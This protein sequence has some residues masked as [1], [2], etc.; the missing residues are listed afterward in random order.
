MDSS[1]AEI[2]TTAATT[3][4]VLSVV[5]FVLGIIGL[6]FNLLIFVRPKLCRQP[7]SFYFFSASWY[8]LF[9]VLIVIPMRLLSN[10]YNLE[11]A[12]YNLGYCKIQTFFIYTIRSI[13]CWLIALATIDRYLH[14]SSNAFLRQMSSA[15]S[16]KWAIRIISMIMF[17]LYCH[18]IVYYEISYVPNKFGTITPLCNGRSGFYRSFLSFWYMLFYSLLPSFMMVVFGCLTVRNIRQRARIAPIAARNVQ[19]FRRSDA[20][21]LRMLA[22]QVMVIIICT[23]P[24]SV[25]RLYSSFTANLTKTTYRLAQEN[26]ALQIVGGLTYFAHSSSFYMHILSSTIFRKELRQIMRS[27]VRRR[28]VVPVYLHAVGQNQ[29]SIL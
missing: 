7:C 28:V 29:T 22:A 12:N 24:F 27:C 11:A 23:V 14:S 18:M 21:I 3:F 26:L 19:T 17:I 15:K 9:I 4:Y 16:A 25:Y 13:S 5:N 2:N 1:T 10:N 20:A 6:A 8:N